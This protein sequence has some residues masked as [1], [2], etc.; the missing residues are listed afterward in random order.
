MYK[1]TAIQACSYTGM[2]A[3]HI[4]QGT[5]HAYGARAGKSLSAQLSS[6][7]IKLGVLFSTHTKGRLL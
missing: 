5:L 7:W 6:I 4:I 1:T 2:A 3:I